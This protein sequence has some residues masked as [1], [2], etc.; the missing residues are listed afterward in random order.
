M[1]SAGDFSVWKWLAELLGPGG[2]VAFIAASAE[3]W[4]IFKMHGWHRDE[5][6]EFHNLC[7]DER[8]EWSVTIK[9]IEKERRERSL[10]YRKDIKEQFAMINSFKTILDEMLPALVKSGIADRRDSKHGRP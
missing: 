9:G 3:A 8:D 10:Q 5:R 6:L 1:E 7:K 2:F 4:F